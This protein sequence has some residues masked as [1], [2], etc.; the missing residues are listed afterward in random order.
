MGDEA[1]LIWVPL[2]AGGDGEGDRVVVE[3]PS[4]NSGIVPATRPAG[5]DR[6]YGGA[7]PG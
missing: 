3:V 2:D 1:R 6:G 4:G 7:L 5:G